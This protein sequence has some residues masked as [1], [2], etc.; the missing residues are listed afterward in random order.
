MA[1]NIP[2]AYH[3]TSQ[4]FDS[5]KHC[6]TL[7][8][9]ELATAIWRLIDAAGLI[10]TELRAYDAVGVEEPTGRGFQLKIKP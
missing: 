10:V 9:D 1:N 3:L 5:I 6:E 7:G 2:E 4:A 8:K